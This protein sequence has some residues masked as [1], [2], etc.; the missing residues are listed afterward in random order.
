M[1]SPKSALPIL[2]VGG[3]LALLGVLFAILLLAPAAQASCNPNAATVEVDLSTLPAGSVAGYSGVQLV[4]AAQ[5]LAAGADAGL[6][7]RDQT[8]GVMTAMGESG[9]RV[10][11]YGDLAGPDSRGLF[12]QRDNGA[13][14][15]LADRMDPYTSAASFF[16]VLAALPERQA[17][18]PTILAH[19]VQR[20]ADPYY[21]ETYWDAAI[22]VVDA[23]GHT[24]TGLAAGTG[25][26]SCTGLAGVPG[27]VNT[28]GWGQPATGPMSSGYGMRF[29]PIYHQW[30]LHA[31]LDLSAG[32]CDAPIWA[33]G[34]G[35]VVAAG[36]S[37]GY[38]NLIEIDHGG[39]VHTRYAHMFANAILVRVGDQVEGGQNI[40]RVGSDGVSTGC[41]LHFE[42]LVNGATVDPAPFLASVGVNVQ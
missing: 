33:A 18:A 1:A 3:P 36:P 8:I 41:H 22:E 13:W 24:T 32:V 5:I 19:Q 12:Q 4:N 26:A 9:L 11:D 17:A 6:G 35:T 2:A 21:Y 25:D 7:A 40:A 42:V 37:T 31:G 30:R 20:N 10:L 27:V 38:G 23:L 29:H 14:G 39:G 34:P 15:S 16:R 28:D